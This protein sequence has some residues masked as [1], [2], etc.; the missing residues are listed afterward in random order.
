MAAELAAEAFPTPPRLV[1]PALGRPFSP[2]AAGVVHFPSP[3]RQKL[4][5]NVAHVFANS[6]HAASGG[7][8]NECFSLVALLL[9]LIAAGAALLKSLDYRLPSS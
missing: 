1:I 7:R 2:A 3:L 5:S 9:V 6:K 8:P 4:L